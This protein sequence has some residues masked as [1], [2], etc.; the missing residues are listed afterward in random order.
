MAI[1][2]RKKTVH[3]RLCAA[4]DR[5][6]PKVTRPALQTRPAYH[7]IDCRLS[8]G[9]S[10]S[11]SAVDYQTIQEDHLVFLTKFVK[12]PFKDARKGLKRVHIS[13]NELY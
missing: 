4:Y 3:K 11:S 7:M 5:P 9:P 12:K 1:A 13:R 6:A 8:L 2:V 10:A